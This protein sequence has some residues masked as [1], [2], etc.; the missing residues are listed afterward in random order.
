MARSLGVARDQLVEPST[1]IREIRP[2]KIRHSYVRTISGIV[3]KCIFNP[4]SAYLDFT[5]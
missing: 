5:W 1:K 2:P 3:F 4:L